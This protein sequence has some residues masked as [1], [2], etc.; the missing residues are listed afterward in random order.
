MG[1]IVKF[2][3][4]LLVD[5]LVQAHLPGPESSADKGQSN[6]R[7]KDFQKL[8]AFTFFPKQRLVQEKPVQSGCPPR[9]AAMTA[10]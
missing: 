4:L 1:F 2:C 3:I 8:N 7:A 6:Y 5:S 10:V 9:G